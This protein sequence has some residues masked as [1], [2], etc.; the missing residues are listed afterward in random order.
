MMKSHRWALDQNGGG[1]GLLQSA[2]LQMN[3]RGGESLFTEESQVVISGHTPGSQ[4]D[5]F[6][7][8][9][10]GKTVHRSV[11]LILR[12]EAMHPHRVPPGFPNP[13]PRDWVFPPSDPR[14]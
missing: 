5:S 3:S 7:L 8:T 12:S 9:D 6:Q 13:E 11:C 10:S 1:A 14:V 2:P 4:R